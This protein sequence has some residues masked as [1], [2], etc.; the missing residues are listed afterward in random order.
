MEPAL[1]VEEV[2][3]LLQFHPNT[4]YSAVREGRL[5]SFRVGKGRGAEYRIWPSDLRKFSERETEAEP[6]V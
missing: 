4:V 3:K 2:A 5:K 6:A 1:T